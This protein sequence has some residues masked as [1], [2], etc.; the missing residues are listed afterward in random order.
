MSEADPLILLPGMGAD[1]RM[2]SSLRGE[3]PQIV[4]PPWIEPRPRESL[5]DYARRFAPMIDPGRPFFIGGASLGGI[6]ALEVAAV[7]PHVRACFVIGSIRSHNS[8]PW[9]V[10]ILRPVTPLVG[11]VPR[12]SPVLVRLLGRWLRSPT[13]GVLIQLAD[14]NPR[15]LRWASAAILKWKPSPETERVRV[16]QIHGD[17]DR[18][19]PVHMTAADCVVSGAGHLISITHSDAVVEFLRQTMERIQTEE[20][21]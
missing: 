5:V 11:L 17:R 6:M 19:F 18:V 10:K 15:F 21:S 4:T 7:L 3:L 9:H 12:L 14:A 13:R 2:F 1:A 16:H 20:S 8:R